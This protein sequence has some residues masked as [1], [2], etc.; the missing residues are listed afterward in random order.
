MGK[1]YAIP[2]FTFFRTGEAACSTGNQDDQETRKQRAALEYQENHLTW[3]VQ[4]G[5]FI[6]GSDLDLCSTRRTD[7]DTR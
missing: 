3:S 7:Q 6:Q 4:P 5:K 2:F 1:L